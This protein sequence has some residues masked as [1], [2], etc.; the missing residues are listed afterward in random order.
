MGATG[1]FARYRA[2]SR[3]SMA[4]FR[5]VI[6]SVWVVL[7]V[8]CVVAGFFWGRLLRR[9]LPPLPEKRAAPDR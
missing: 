4:T 1:P 8:M 2:G 5:L 3:R 6:G 9:P 7:A